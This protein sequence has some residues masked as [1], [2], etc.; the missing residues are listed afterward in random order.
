MRKLERKIT[1]EETDLEVAVLTIGR[2]ERRF[3]NGRGGFGVGA[4][5]LEMVLARLSRLPVLVRSRSK[6]VGGIVGLFL[7]RTRTRIL[8]RPF[9]GLTS[10]SRITSFSN[11]FVLDDVVV[12][13]VDVVVVVVVEVVVVDV[14]VVVVV[15]LVV[16]LLVANNRGRKRLTV[17]LISAGAGPETETS[18]RPPQVRTQSSPDKKLLPLP[19]HPEY[20]NF[21]QVLVD[22][23]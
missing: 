13:V 7:C 8:R 2:E 1:E 5:V 10:A 14:V 23:S 20:L 22:G 19:P 4:V 9:I 15:V 3:L 11:S 17:F 18:M 6:D 21:L 16:V 12:V